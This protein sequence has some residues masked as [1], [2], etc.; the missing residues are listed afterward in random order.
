LGQIEIFFKAV[1]VITSNVAR[2]ALMDFA[3]GMGIAVP[4]AFPST[5]GLGGTLNLISGG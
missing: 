3:G 2:V 4:N 5:I 1:V